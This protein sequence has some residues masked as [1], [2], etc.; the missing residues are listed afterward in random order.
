M[1]DFRVI[2]AMTFLRGLA[3]A[4]AGVLFGIYLAKLGYAPG[5]MGLMVGAG[6]AGMTAGTLAVTLAGDRWGRRRSLLIL[7]VMGAGGGVAAGASSGFNMMAAAAFFGM[8]NGMGRD[9]GPS[10]VLEHTILASTTSDERRTR[11]FAWYNVLQDSGHALGGLLVALPMALRAWGGA[12]EMESFRL[13]MGVYAVLIL[14]AALPS[15][16]LSSAVEAPAARGATKVSKDTRRF[17]WRISTLFGL[18]SLGGGFLATALLAY[19]FY[20]RFGVSEISIG[21]LFFGAR[22]ANAASHLGAA[23]LAKRIGLVNTMVFT[24]I[25]SSVLLATVAFAPSFPIAALLFIVREGLVEMDVPTRQSYV[26]AIVRPEERMVASGVTHLVR[27]GGWAVAPSFAGLFMQGLSLATPLFFGAGLKVTYD[28]ML[29]KA[30]RGL[31]PPEEM[32]DGSP[33]SH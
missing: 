31:R 1:K 32:K 23:W 14:A 12:G 15:L 13:S 30:F 10:L 28:L 16:L 8:I 7:G 11:A 29:Y 24:H 3:T 17:L 22:V 33:G 27:N 9:R 19:F 20:A 5:Q 21:L 4:M 6:L 26:M 18:D 2:C 25:P